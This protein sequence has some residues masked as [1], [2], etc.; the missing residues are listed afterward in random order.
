MLDTQPDILPEGVSNL[1]GHKIYPVLAKW[2]LQSCSTRH[3]HCMYYHKLT[4]IQGERALC[5]HVYKKKKEKTIRLLYLWKEVVKD[6]FLFYFFLADLKKMIILS[7]VHLFLNSKVPYT[8][9]IIVKCHYWLVHSML[10][11]YM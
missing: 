1:K 7:L 9:R 11:L 6:R 5:A 10:N 2:L 8:G 4:L 3:I